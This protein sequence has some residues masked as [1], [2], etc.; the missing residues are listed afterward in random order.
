[1]S[2]EVEEAYTSYLTSQLGMQSAAEQAR[3]ARQ[4]AV[5]VLER[6][7]VGATDMNT[8]VTTL[9]AAILAA[10]AY[11]TAVRSYNSAVATLYRSSARWPDGTQTLLEQRVGALKRQ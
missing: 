3:A 10:N 2:R 6:F 9:N 4:A 5:A 11:A 1:M 7:S 8:V